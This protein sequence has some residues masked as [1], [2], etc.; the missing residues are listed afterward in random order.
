[1]DLEFIVEMPKKA[2]LECKSGAHFK[3]GFP[4]NL[5]LEEYVPEGN[6]TFG[7]GFGVKIIYF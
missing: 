1:M 3:E 2:N 4:T 6:F 5:D 7:W